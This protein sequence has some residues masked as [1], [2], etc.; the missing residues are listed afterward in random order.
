MLVPTWRPPIFLYST[1]SGLLVPDPARV[2][3]AAQSL[4][5][6]QAPAISPAAGPRSG[7]LERLPASVLG[8]RA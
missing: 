8:E 3:S 2:H 7:T 4:H 5:L 1:R 6:G